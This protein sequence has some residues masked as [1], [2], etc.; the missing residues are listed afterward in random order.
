[1]P[2]HFHWDAGMDGISGFSTVH[3]R[4]TPMEGD[5]GQTRTG[6]TGQQVSETSLP[7]LR[8]EVGDTGAMEAS[9]GSQAG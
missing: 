8:T 1:M 6:S 2:L 9:V 7:L 3:S 4:D 5:R